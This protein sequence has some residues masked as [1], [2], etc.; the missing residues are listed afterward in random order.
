MVKGIIEVERGRLEVLEGLPS[1]ASR[2]WS[3]FQ[4]CRRAHVVAGRSEENAPQSLVVPVGQLSLTGSPGRQSRIAV[5]QSE[6]A[7]CQGRVSDGVPDDVREA[8]GRCP[9]CR[10]RLR[11]ERLGRAPGPLSTLQGPR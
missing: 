1:T 2:A 6:L 8:A 4:I 11:R 9:R 5:V 3:S 10:D 7:K